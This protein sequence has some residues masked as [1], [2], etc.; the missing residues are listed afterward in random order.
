[1]TN[2]NDFAPVV[3]TAHPEVYANHTFHMQRAKNFTYNYSIIDEVIVELWD[4]MTIEQIAEA[5]NEYPN[6]V[7]YRTQVLRKL[8]LIKSKHTGKTALLKEQRKLRMRL[9][10]I[11]A[12]LNE[13]SAA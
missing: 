1:M 5:M 6:R 4:D 11:E 9:K 13:I 2:T 8:G 3:K 7:I 10:K 12:E